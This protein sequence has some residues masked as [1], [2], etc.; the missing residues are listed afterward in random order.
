M[1]RSVVGVI[2]GFIAWM[3]A[4]FG[5]E[6]VLAALSPAGFGAPQR[7]FE[8][9]LVEGHAFTAPASLL[10]AQ[11]VLGSLVSLLAGFV[12]ALVAR[13]SRRAPL[14]LGVLLSA[15]GVLKAVMSWPLVPVWF[16]LVFTALLLPLAMLGGRLRRAR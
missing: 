6:S 3:V 9:A 2:A 13:E 11:L 8:A 15:M 10:V 14:V 16:H 4:W 1:V 5:G 7:A 12:A